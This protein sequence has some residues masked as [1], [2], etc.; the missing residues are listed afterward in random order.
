M[1]EYTP[2][3]WFYKPDYDEPHDEIGGG[4]EAFNDALDAVD[5]K[6]ESLGSV[7]KE[8]TESNIVVAAD[9]TTDTIIENTCNRGLVHYLKVSQTGDMTSGTY[10]VEFYDSTNY[11]VLL[12]KAVD[13]SSEEDYEDYLP[14]WVKDEEEFS[15]FYI[16]IT[17]NES[18]EAIFT[19]EMH[20]EKFA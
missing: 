17:N 15:Q 9:S 2:N 5:A 8:T 19:I 16:R 14:F 1:G 7:A 3:G 10:N 18:V 12:Y 20:Y 13:I 6:I 4:I 11:D